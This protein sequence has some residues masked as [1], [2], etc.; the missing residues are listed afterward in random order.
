MIRPLILVA[1][2]AGPVQEPSPQVE[3]TT[4]A[5]RPGA[6]SEL[7]AEVASRGFRPTLLDAVQLIVNEESITTSDLL[8]GAARQRNA[9]TTEAE[10]NKRLGEQAQQLVKSTLKK[11]AGRDMG[12]EPALVQSLVR[13]EL[14]KRKEQAGS[15]SALARDL[16]QGNFRGTELRE[17]IEGYIYSI[18][19]ERSVNGQYPGPGGRPYVDRFVR[20]GRLLYEFRRRGSKLD[21]PTQVRLEEL[22][23]VPGRGESLESARQR[24]DQALARYEQGEEFTDL[25]LE[26][27]PPNSRPVLPL[28]EER[29]LALRAEIKAFIDGAEPGDVSEVLPLP[30]PNGQMVGFRVLRFVERLGGKAASFEDR[31]LQGKLASEIQEQLDGYRVDR[32]LKVLLDAA[33]IWPPEY[34]G[35]ERPADAKDEEVEEIEATGG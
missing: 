25:A 11:Q 15:V 9:A 26:F 18:L 14:E 22:I 10:L 2:L 21:L 7:P 32:A 8:R 34:V 20:P 12:F 19:W 1:L 33:Y 35:R 5:D 29:K 6:A 30:G 27:G 23:L 28:M 16:D 24:A 4:E 3:P 31:E 17:Y 13:D